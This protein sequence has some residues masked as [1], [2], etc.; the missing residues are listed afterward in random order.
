MSLIDVQEAQRRLLTL[1]EVA[2]RLG[3]TRRTVERKVHAGEI[4]AL[5]LGG[6]RSPLRVDERELDAWLYGKGQA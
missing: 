6:P 1:G 4:P 5:Q 3:V 2:D